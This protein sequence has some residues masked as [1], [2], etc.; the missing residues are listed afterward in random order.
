MNKPRRKLIG[1]EGLISSGKSTLAKELAVAL[2]PTTLC[3][4][5]PDEK[6]GANPYLAS[7]YADAA[8]WSLTMQMHLLGKRFRMQ[9]HAQWH[10]LE[11]LGDSV[12]DRTPYG[13]TAFAHLQLARGSM[14]EREFSTYEMIYQAMT[15]NMLLPNIL[16]RT[17]TTPERCNERLVK[18]MERETGRRC[19][20]AIDLDY[21]RALEVEINH[22]VN[23]L[24]DQGVVVLDMPWDTDRDSPES[25][26][27]AVE[28]LASRIHAIQPL[29]RLL[30]DH[31]RTT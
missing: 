10:A 27:D 8:R 26:K 13:D 22:M 31:R 21:L 7:Y 20:Q 5:E 6:G 9:M 28:A 19:E 29:N 15:A 12:V 14:S 23:V 24:R 25:R 11:G 1:I 18:R 2:G 4:L 17:L 30:D 16:V 3:L